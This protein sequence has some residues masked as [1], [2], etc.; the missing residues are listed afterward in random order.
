MSYT[1]IDNTAAAFDGTK[2]LASLGNR[3]IAVINGES[4]R[5]YEI[6]RQAGYMAALETLGLP[7]REELVVKTGY[8]YSDGIRAIDYLLS[9]KD[10]PEAVFAFSDTLA[11]GSLHGALRK[12]LQPGK[13]I[14]IMGFDN[15]QLSEMVLPQLSTVG[16]PQYD[17]G[18]MS[19][20]LL[21]E[22]IQNK[23]AITKG[24]ILPYTIVQRESTRPA[25][26]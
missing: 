11:V 25:G 14:D 16:Q 4:D 17:L 15:I 18:A 13:D 5:S 20:D 12:N 24:V 6:S 1:C 19:F 7:C 9:L 23:S 2:F 21:H 22:K 8:D 3:S 26:S 10:P